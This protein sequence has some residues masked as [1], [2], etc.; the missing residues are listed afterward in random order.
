[1]SLSLR[2]RSLALVTVCSTAAVITGC[3]G[4]GGKTAMSTDPAS[5]ESALGVPVQALID[6]DVSALVNQLPAAARAE[7]ER[8]WPEMR[9]ELARE[10]GEGLAMLSDSAKRSEMRQQ[11]VAGLAMVSGFMKAG[12]A[13]MRANLDGQL[14]EVNAAVGQLGGS[15]DQAQ[16]RAVAEGMIDWLLEDSGF[17]DTDKT[18]KAFDVIVAAIDSTGLTSADDIKALSLTQG[19]THAGTMLGAIKEVAAIHNFDINAMLSSMTV[20]S[21]D[22]DGD[23]RTLNMAMTLFGQSLS[24]PGVPVVKDGAGW[25]LPFDAMAPGASAPVEPISVEEA[26]IDVAPVE[27]AEE[28]Q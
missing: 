16:A 10:M 13:E 17:G 24:M 9:E 15:V 28:A 2:L 3:G 4:G 18:G 7:L 25:S 11:A 19:L 23:Q 8:E 27:A 21:V 6:N 5:P 1:M 14:N 12:A 22:G 26:T 20:T